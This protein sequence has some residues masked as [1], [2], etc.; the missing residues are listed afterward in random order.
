MLIR[1]FAPLGSSP[2]CPLRCTLQS[3]NEAEFVKLMSTV[4]AQPYGNADLE[5]YMIVRL[6]QSGKTRDQNT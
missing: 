5:Y 1:F 4:S 3:C 6:S 2:T